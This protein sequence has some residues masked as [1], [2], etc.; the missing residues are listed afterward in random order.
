MIIFKRKTM[1]K[2][3]FPPGV[4]IQTNVK[5][6]MDESMMGVWL[7]RCCVKRPD[8]FFQRNK[9]LLVMDSMRAHITEGV[10]NKI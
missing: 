10:K 9:A 8:G 1:P 6:W 3:A 2:E 4:V 7:D 5:G